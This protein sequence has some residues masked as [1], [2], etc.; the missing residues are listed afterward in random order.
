MVEWVCV[1]KDL[2]GVLIFKG[3]YVDIGFIDWVIEVYNQIIDEEKVGSGGGVD[4]FV[5]VGVNDWIWN[6]LQKLCLKVLGVFVEYF[7]NFVFDMVCE[8]WFGLNYQ[9]I[10]QVNLVCL[11]GVV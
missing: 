11:G 5:V 9:M 3:V 7:V 4:Y 6:L 10:M 1:L 2:F 8:V